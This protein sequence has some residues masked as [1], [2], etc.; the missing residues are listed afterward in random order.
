MEP[1]DD[2]FRDALRALLG[3][4][5]L[6]ARALS[7][8]MGRDPGYVSA[9][10]DPARPSR[11][12]PT[13]ADLLRA[14]DATGMPLVDLLELLWAIPRERVMAELSGRTLDAAVAG[15]TM[16]ERELVGDL[17][18]FLERR[19]DALGG[20]SHP[21]RPRRRRPERILRDGSR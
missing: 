16:S 10:L 12:R 4:T 6:S 1:T 15:L 14:S 13:P 18:T 9:L 5:R 21:E 11:A 7:S 19:R 2:A 17:I 3:R 8:A 20:P